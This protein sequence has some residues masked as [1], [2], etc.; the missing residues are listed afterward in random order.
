MNRC[1]SGSPFSFGRIKYFSSR[2]ASNQA[3]RKSAVLG[4]GLTR[5]RDRRSLGEGPVTGQIFPI[6]A[7]R[8]LAGTDGV[9]LLSL[10][11]LVVRAVGYVDGMHFDYVDIHRLAPYDTYPSGLCSDSFRLGFR[12][13]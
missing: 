5:L 6:L 4:L 7:R 11:R 3:G 13:S 8:A 2:Q 9:C 10:A 12:L 1:G